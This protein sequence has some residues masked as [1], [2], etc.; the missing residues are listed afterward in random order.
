MKKK[1]NKKQRNTESGLT[2]AEETTSI[3]IKSEMKRGSGSILKLENSDKKTISREQIKKEVV[4]ELFSLR[5]VL[6]EILERR[7]SRLE[8]RIHALSETLAHGH[9]PNDETKLLKRSD[10]LKILGSIRI[11][12][13]RPKKARLKDLKKIDRLIHK[14]EEM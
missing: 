13:L 3:E 12:D 10:L 8:G 9:S 5:K 4:E 11:L 14:L 7:I 2:L 1:T 6:K